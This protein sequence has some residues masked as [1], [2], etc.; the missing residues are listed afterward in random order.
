[1]KGFQMSRRSALLAAAV[2]IAALGTFL[3]YLYVQSI[4]QNAYAD[5]DP[6]TVLVAK[7]AVAVGT[8]G[9]AAVNGGAF[10]E[11]VLPRGAVPTDSVAD[12]SVVAANVAVT[13]ILPGQVIQQSM[14]GEKAINGQLPLEKGDIALSVQ[15]GDPQRVA[16]FVQPGSQ[17]AV[18][19][20]T[21]DA[22]KLLLADVDVAAVGP[23]TAVKESASGDGNAESIPTAILTLSLSQRQAEKLVFAQ[24]NGDLYLGLQNTSSELGQSSG[25]NAGNLFN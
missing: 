22:T 15:L 16:G 6:V 13:T 12:A 3:V 4:Q 23:T 7:E 10:E 14:F 17:V 24:A 1:V 5:Q 18:F 19:A 21:D 25:A 2:A 8:S 9:G 11:K 20:T